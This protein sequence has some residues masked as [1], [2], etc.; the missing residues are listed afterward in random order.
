MM[1][2]RATAATAVR[3]GSALRAGNRMFASIARQSV[4]QTTPL[5]QLPAFASVRYN[6]SVVD[7]STAKS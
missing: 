3:T 5:R 2:F 7:A 6:S 4:A 1:F